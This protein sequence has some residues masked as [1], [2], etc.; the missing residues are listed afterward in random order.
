MYFSDA[1]LA[2]IERAAQ[3]EGISVDDYVSR[4]VCRAALGRAGAAMQEVAEDYSLIG[5][6][7]ASMQP[8]GRPARPYKGRSG[9]VFPFIRRLS[10]GIFEGL[11]KPSEM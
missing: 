8:Q 3:E 9:K 4:A 1:E 6:A 2:V 11:K 5:A 10:G 7:E